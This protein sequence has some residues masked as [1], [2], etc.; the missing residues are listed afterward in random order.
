MGFALADPPADNCCAG[1]RNLSEILAYLPV[2][3]LILT[4]LGLLLNLPYRWLLI[5]FSVQFVAAF[6]LIL[7]SWPLGLAAV[8]LLVGWMAVAIIGSSINEEESPT[9]FNWKLNDNFFKIIA[10]LLILLLAFSLG[11]TAFQWIPASFAVISGGL[12]LAGLGLLQLGLSTQPFR[13]TIGLLTLLSGFDII[14]A[15]VVNSV[16]VAGL[17]ALVSLGLAFLGAYLMN[18]EHL[19]DQP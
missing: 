11:N 5:L 2:F 18:V 9:D 14:Y 1:G 4:G 7:L 12:V 6:W 19:E 16:L 15:A 17:S 10:G 3:I 13:T 8:K